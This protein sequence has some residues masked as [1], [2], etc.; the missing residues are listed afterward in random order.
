MKRPIIAL[1]TD[2]GNEDFFAASL[3]AVVLSLQPEASIIDLSH[4]V[5]SF[6]IRRG[7]FLLAAC[8]KFFPAGT[9]FV[10]VVDPGV[11]SKRRILLVKTK[12]YFFVAPD[13]GVLSHVLAEE[14]PEW[15]IHVVNRRFFFEGA[16]R[17]FDGRDRMAPV[18]AWLSLGCAPEE[19]GPRTSKCSTF[20]IARP[21]FLKNR[22]IGQVAYID[23]FGNCLTN[24]PSR[25]IFALLKKNG[26]K[27]LTLSLGRTTTGAFKESYASGRRGELLILPGSA[28]TLEIA[29]R[30]VSAADLSGAGPGS[31]V[32]VLVAG[33]RSA[34]L[35]R[36]GKK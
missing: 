27:K 20:P 26:K 3:K 34:N 31:K 10:V 32:M 23:K 19:F 21:K 22:I 12:K 36:P 16:G 13:N 33:R 28:G 15:M 35:R 25:P 9:I 6:D 7:S 24:I 11:G 18:A 29:A 2:Y 5:P 8:Y 30:E 17:T 4:S 14:E 1:L